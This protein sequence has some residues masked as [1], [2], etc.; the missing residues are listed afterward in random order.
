MKRFVLTALVAALIPL[1]SA[2]AFQ[3]LSLDEM[4]EST[5]F[6]GNYFQDYGKVEETSNFQ[7]QVGGSNRANAYDRGPNYNSALR[8]NGNYGRNSG[9]MFGSSQQY[10]SSG[11]SSASMT[12]LS[13]GVVNSY[14]CQR[15]R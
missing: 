2:S 1:G 8:G 13:Y 11:S 4:Q 5:S 6:D 9:G 10:C 12:A 14:P 15:F 3:V 7:F